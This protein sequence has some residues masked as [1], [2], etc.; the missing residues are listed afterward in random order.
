LFVMWLCLNFVYV[1]K[2]IGILLS[3]HA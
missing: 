3:K 1:A 2:A